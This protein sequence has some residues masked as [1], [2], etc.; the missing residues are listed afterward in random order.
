LNWNFFLV[1]ALI[2]L[3]FFIVASRVA[4]RFSI[5]QDKDGNPASP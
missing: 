2:T 3:T 1:R 5:A 4:R